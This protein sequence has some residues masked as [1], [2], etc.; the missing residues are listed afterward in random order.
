[1]QIITLEYNIK[2][3]KGDNRVKRTEQNEKHNLQIELTN[4]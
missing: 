4:R 3:E 1:M 2:P